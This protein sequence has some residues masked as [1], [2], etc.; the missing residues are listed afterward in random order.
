MKKL[1]TV[2]IALIYFTFSTGATVHLHY[3]MGE[4]ISA[5]LFDTN[6]GV[7]DNCGMNE[8]GNNNDCCQDVQVKAKI[9]DSHHVSPLY[10]C[11]ETPSIIVPPSFTISTQVRIYATV[12]TTFFAQPHPPSGLSHPLFIQYRNIRI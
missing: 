1:V 12:P 2:F 3:C 6:K 10:Y 7:C 9:S 5:S 11:P 8:S 4:Y